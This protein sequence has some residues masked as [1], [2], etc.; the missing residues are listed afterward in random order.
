MRRI[1]ATIVTGFLGAG[2]TSLVRHLLSAAAGHRLAVIV[3]EFGELGIDRDLLLGCGD[4]NCRDEDI[5]ELANGC[6]CC[7]VADD[8]LPALTRLIERAEPPGHIVIET[9]GL[10][11]PKPLVQAFAW[12][13]IRTRMTV[14]GVVTVIDAAAVAAGRFAD[15]P[16]AVAAQR[17]ADGAIDHD[18]PLQEVF[19][20][21]LACADL[22]VMNKA[23]LIGA[24]EAAALRADVEARLRPGVKLVAAEQGRVP[25]AVALGLGA[26]AEDDLAARPSLHEA[27]GEHDHD[28]FDSF[29]IDLGPLADPALLRD[30]LGAAIRAQNVLRIKGFA[31][32]PGRDRRL[33]IQAVGARIE[34]HF[35]RAW[36]PGEARATRLV[37][38]G[39]KG[40]DR[41]AVAAALGSG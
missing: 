20:D 9:S 10:A 29:V 4:E 12:P 22:V 24:S 15:D 39:R 33:S 30:R 8:F 38:I 2:K 18:N 34:Q 11:L 14:D 6:L 7:T 13:E 3:N 1:P 27:D 40:L 31:D 26:T 19:A 35:D 28:D 25:L 37:V 41:A 23:D 36:I 5:V 17:G 16:A 32:V 21:Q